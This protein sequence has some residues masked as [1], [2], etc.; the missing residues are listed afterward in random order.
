MQISRKGPGITQLFSADD[1]LLFSKAKPEEAKE[2]RRILKVYK[3]A[4]GQEIN[5]EKSTIFF[6][7]NTK[8]EKRTECIQQLE[9]IQHVLHGKY[10][11]LPLVVGRSKNSVFRYIREKALGKLKS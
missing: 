1:S 6:C 4:S 7:K 2:I 3:K 5:M 10:L 11:G 9:Q 8:K